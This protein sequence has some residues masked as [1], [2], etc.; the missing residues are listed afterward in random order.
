[1]DSRA[2]ERAVRRHVNGLIERLAAGRFETYTQFRRRFLRGLDA[3]ARRHEEVYD[4]DV[5]GEITLALQ[6]PAAR[7]GYRTEDLFFG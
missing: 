6:V 7:S 3:I 2:G 1:M 5:L 4:D